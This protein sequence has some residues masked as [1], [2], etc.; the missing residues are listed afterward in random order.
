VDEKAA[1]RGLEETSREWLRRIARLAAVQARDAEGFRRA[2]RDLGAL[3]QPRISATGGVL[4]YSV[5]AVGDVNAAGLPVWYSGSNL[6]ADLSMPKLAARWASAPAP[7]AP[8]PPAEGEHSRVGRQERAAAVVEA[9]SAI[10]HATA[11]LAAGQLDDAAGI[12]HAAEDMLNAVEAVTG[13]AR[14]QRRR[15]RRIST[16]GPPDPLGLGS[17]PAGGRWPR[18]CAAHRGG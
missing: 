9:T 13:R 5:S 10:E 12:A 14:P 16:S 15:A 11:A 6:A 17:R 8:I 7:T 1:R 2:V 4:G 18:S 3:Y